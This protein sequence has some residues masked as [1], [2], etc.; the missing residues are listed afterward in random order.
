MSDLKDYKRECLL[1]EHESLSRVV[2]QELFA[3]ALIRSLTLASWLIA[4]TAAA[5]YEVSILV[6]LITVG[7]AGTGAWLT[8]VYFSYVGVVY[9]MRRKNVRELIDGLPDADDATLR[10]CKTPVNPF[11]SLAG[12]EKKQALRDALVSPWV[13]LP[14]ACLDLGTA[15]LILRLLFV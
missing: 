10:E 11:E 4:M 13:I 6:I 9:K 1:L 2:D 5:A 3:T 15:L 12:G 14:Y 7:A 8:D